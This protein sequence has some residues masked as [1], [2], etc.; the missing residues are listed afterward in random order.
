M[1]LRDFSEMLL[2]SHPDMIKLYQ[3]RYRIYKLLNLDFDL[4]FTEDIYNYNNNIHS[5]LISN[6]YNV[7]Y[8]YV[9]SLNQLLPNTKSR[10]IHQ[11]I[12]YNR[13]RNSSNI[14][15]F[16]KLFIFH[17]NSET[18]NTVYIINIDN[19]TNILYPRDLRIFN[20]IYSKKSFKQEQLNI[21]NDIHSIVLNDNKI[22][23]SEIIH[24]M[25]DK[26]H[27]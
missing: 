22:T 1:N 4:F 19:F 25:E 9:T 7:N 21:I 5:L 20:T 26:Y 27:G 13:F 24:K 15:P 18:E 3:L 8:T 17:L 10:I 14:T 12:N 16:D 23:I 6:L 11:P 2:L